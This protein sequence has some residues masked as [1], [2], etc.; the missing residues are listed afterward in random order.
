MEDI[1]AMRLPRGSSSG[2]N[3][4]AGCTKLLIGDAASRLYSNM[5]L[6]HDASKMCLISISLVFHSFS[7]VA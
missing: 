6:K 3:L 4:E 2:R 5:R 1:L 7:K